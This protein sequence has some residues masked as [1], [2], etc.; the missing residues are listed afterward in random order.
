MFSKCSSLKNILTIDNEHIWQC[1]MII[2]REYES[3]E[4]LQLTTNCAQDL[5]LL[6][7]LVDYHEHN[8]ILVYILKEFWKFI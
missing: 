5:K 1:S 7:K 8:C 6:W 4:L 3:D 2:P